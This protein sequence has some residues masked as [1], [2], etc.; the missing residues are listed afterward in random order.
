MLTIS[1]RRRRWLAGCMAITAAGTLWI[2]YYSHWIYER[3]AFLRKQLQVWQSA[4]LDAKSAEWYLIDAPATRNRVDQRA[5]G[6]LWVFGEEGFS[7]LDVLV[8]DPDS[9]IR[10]CDVRADRLGYIARARELFPEAEIAPCGWN[11]SPASQE[12]V[13]TFVRVSVE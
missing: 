10:D 7:E 4:G 3:H 12:G 13:K 8:R 1:V 6:F 11:R 5:P 2:A 9:E